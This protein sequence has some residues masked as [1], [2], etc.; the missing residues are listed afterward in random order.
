[1]SYVVKFDRYPYL[2]KHGNPTFHPDKAAV[3]A[4]KEKAELSA[5]LC[6]GSVHK[7]IVHE[8]NVSKKREN[9]SQVNKLE[10]KSLTNQA[11]MRGGN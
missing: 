11:W 10:K 4:D 7:K 9:I 8:K 3:F 2:D 5:V 1:M 6:Q